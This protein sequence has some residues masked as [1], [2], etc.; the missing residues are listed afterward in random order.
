ML[1]VLFEAQKR[2]FN[3]PK[4]PKIFLTQMIME[5]ITLFLPF[6]STNLILTFLMSGLQWRGLTANDMDSMLSIFLIIPKNKTE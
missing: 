3:I 6:Q 4:T 5:V 2:V 1:K